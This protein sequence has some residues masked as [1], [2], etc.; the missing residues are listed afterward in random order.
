MNQHFYE[1]TIS[2]SE[3]KPP[4]EKKPA[5]KQSPEENKP[6]RDDRISLARKLRKAKELC[7]PIVKDKT[8]HGFRYA[9][10]AQAT[11]NGGAA[12]IRAGIAA[13]AKVSIIENKFLVYE[14]EL[15]DEE[16]G[17]GLIFP[18]PPIPVVFEQ[19]TKQGPRKLDPAHAIRT[20]TTYAEKMTWCAALTIPQFT[21]Q[22]LSLIHI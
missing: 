8:G 19:Q 13:I 20:A 17:H 21:D 4:P 14:L 11:A 9:T 6:S 15:I 2:T 12:C 18:S 16:T 10:P 7:S 3:A 5:A 1:S 22:D